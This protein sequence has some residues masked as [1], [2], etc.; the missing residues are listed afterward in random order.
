MVAAMA[1]EVEERSDV[2]DSVSMTSVVGKLEPTRLG[3]SDGMMD[4][5]NVTTLAGTSDEPLGSMMVV[6]GRGKTVWSVDV[7]MVGVR[8]DVVKA[9]VHMGLRVQGVASWW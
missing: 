4:P 7:W 5:G 6:V 9:A 3:T 8:R 1:V 2:G